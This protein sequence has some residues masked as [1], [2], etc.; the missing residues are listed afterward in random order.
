LEQD[1]IFKKNYETYL[2]NEEED[3]KDS[4][5]SIDLLTFLS[6]LG[7]E[8]RIMTFSNHFSQKMLTQLHKYLQVNLSVYGEK[9]QLKES[10]IAQDQLDKEP[11]PDAKSGQE[12]ESPK[13]Y[14]NMGQVMFMSSF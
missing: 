8:M 11:V 12:Q 7:F 13:S 6:K 10:I 1:Y 2:Y 5:N 9:C 14:L 3:K 4:V